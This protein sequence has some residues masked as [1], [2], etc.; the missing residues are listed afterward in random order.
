MVTALMM[1]RPVLPT[2]SLTTRVSLRFIS[3][4]AFWMCWTCWAA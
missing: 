4:R 3:W 2:T 1:A